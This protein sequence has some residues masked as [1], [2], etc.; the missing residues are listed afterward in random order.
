MVAFTRKTLTAYTRV[1][2]FHSSDSCSN[3]RLEMK[4]VFNF[5]GKLWPECCFEL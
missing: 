3:A 4:C 1:R 2:N 5:K